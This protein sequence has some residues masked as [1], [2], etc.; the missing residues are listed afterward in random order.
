M[1]M[2]KRKRRKRRDV[3]LYASDVRDN[4]A[5][6]DYGYDSITVKWYFFFSFFQIIVVFPYNV[7]YTCNIVSQ[8]QNVLRQWRRVRFVSATQP[9]RHYHRIIIC[10]AYL[11]AW[12]RI[13]LF[14][15]ERTAVTIESSFQSRFYLYLYLFF[16]QFIFIKCII[17]RNLENNIN[18]Y[19]YIITQI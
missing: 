16:L 3:K 9:S 17:E 6:K 19:I 14:K 2:E 1:R 7:V 5:K 11:Y 12:S 10:V 15:Y 13:V 8:L 18:I 4:C